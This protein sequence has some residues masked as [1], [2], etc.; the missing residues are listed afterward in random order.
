MREYWNILQLR[1]SGC[2][3]ECD[4]MWAYVLSSLLACVLICVWLRVTAIVH[5]AFVCVNVWVCVGMWVW[6]CAWVGVRICVCTC[7]LSP[8][9][10]DLKPIRVWVSWR[11]FRVLSFGTKWTHSR[12]IFRSNAPKLTSQLFCEMPTGRRNNSK[13]Y[14]VPLSRAKKL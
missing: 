1:E 10:D 13:S 7:V 3:C 14:W 12:S 11:Q 9:A 6:I 8:S 5:Y 4:C 2:I